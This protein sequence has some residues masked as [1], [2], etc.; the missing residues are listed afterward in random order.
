MVVFAF[1]NLG[2]IWN[3][4][5]RSRKTDW[6]YATGARNLTLAVA[7]ILDASAIIANYS[8]LFLDY[9]RKSD[10]ASCMRPDMGGIP[11]PGNLDLG[12]EERI[13]R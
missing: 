8:P 12:D 13:L 1:R 10:D 6:G 11:I 4:R 5:R 9:N 2:K 3:L 7:Q